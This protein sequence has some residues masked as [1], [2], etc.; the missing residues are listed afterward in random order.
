MGEIDHARL[1]RPPGE[2]WVKS[3][4]RFNTGFAFILQMKG[5]LY[6]MSISNWGTTLEPGSSCSFCLWYFSSVSEHSFNLASEWIWDWYWEKTLISLLWLHFLP[7]RNYLSKHSSKV[8]QGRNKTET[9][10]KNLESPAKVGL[11]LKTLGKTHLPCSPFQ[12]RGV[13]SN[14][15]T[16]RL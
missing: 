8:G 7:C 1:M 12:R 4:S 10:H 9:A 13:S 2:V 11:R 15:D 14:R 16:R 5:Q 6:S 3:A